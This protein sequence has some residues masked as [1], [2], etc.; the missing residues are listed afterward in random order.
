MGVRSSYVTLIKVIP[1]GDS[2]FDEKIVYSDRFKTIFNNSKCLSFYQKNKKISTFPKI[3]GL[4]YVC[5][6]DVDALSL[7]RYSYEKDTKYNDNDFDYYYGEDDDEYSHYGH[8]NDYY[9]FSLFVKNKYSKDDRLNYYFFELKEPLIVSAY[10]DGI[11]AKGKIFI[12]FYPFGC[13]TIIAALSLKGIKNLNQEELEL[14][15]SKISPN[16][17]KQ[18]WE[19]RCK[20]GNMSLSDIIW[21]V[22]KRLN[23]SLFLN[24]YKLDLTSKW[25]KA[26]SY[27]LIDKK[28]EDANYGYNEN[29]TKV[30]INNKLVLKNELTESPD[31]W[32]VR[33]YRLRT[34]WRIIRL[35]ELVLIKKELYL[36]YI[37]YLDSEILG[38]RDY[39]LGSLKSKFSPEYIKKTTTY[40]KQLA[41]FI[42]YLDDVILSS[43]SRYKFF[44]FK[45]CDI[46]N[47]N[48]LRDRLL[49]SQEKWVEECSNFKNTL[50]KLLT[51]II[52]IIK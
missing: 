23:T 39:R 45:I 42:R 47:L 37:G 4:G 13:V 29:C 17:I 5:L 34:Y 32:H 28:K 50:I 21:N 18:E 3:D 10:K 40:D 52:S 31:D 22:E 16:K 41:A 19:W 48:K 38:M 9:S 36:K 46:Y 24:N 43:S 15:I 2:L 20:W 44:Y 8:P 6:N 30:F 14:S 26:Y 49:I 12:H 1:F 7:N 33:Q 25:D 11:K 35:Q 27:T 51:K